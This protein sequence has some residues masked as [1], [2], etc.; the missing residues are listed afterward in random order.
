MIAAI[1]LG[2]YSSIEEYAE[3]FVKV[4]AYTELYQIYRQIYTQIKQL[5]Q[6]L[7][8]FRW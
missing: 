4:E 3:H 2:W 6:S 5:N 8:K 7:K 1:D